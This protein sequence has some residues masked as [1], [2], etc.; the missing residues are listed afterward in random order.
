MA[1]RPGVKFATRYYKQSSHE[2]TRLSEFVET[3]YETIV[4]AAHSQGL[5]EELEEPLEGFRRTG[6]QANYS[7]LQILDDLYQQLQLGRDAPEAMIARWNRALP[8]Q[9]A[10]E[11]VEDQPPNPV[12]NQLYYQ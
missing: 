12:F 9:F 7:I 2:Y 8:L 6:K 10:I 5:M 1:P 3:T 4:E 11:L